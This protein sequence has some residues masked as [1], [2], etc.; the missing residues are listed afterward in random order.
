MSENYRNTYGADGSAVSGDVIMNGQT[1]LAQSSDSVFSGCNVRFESTVTIRGKRSAVRFENCIIYIDRDITGLEIRDN[2]EISFTGCTFIDSI[3]DPGSGYDDVTGGR[4]R[5]ALIDPDSDCTLQF[6]RCRFESCS[7]LVGND[8]YGFWHSVRCIFRDCLMHNCGSGFTDLSQFCGSLLVTGCLIKNDSTP[9]ESEEQDLSSILFRS[10]GGQGAIFRI[11]SNVNPESRKGEVIFNNDMF[12][13]TKNCIVV[14]SD[15]KV[16]VKSCTFTNSREC[17][18]GVSSVQNCLFTGCSDVMK[19]TVTVESCCFDGCSDVIKQLPRGGI[20]KDCQFLDCR[21]KLVSAEKGGS[22]VTDCEFYG[23]TE[24][25]FD[26]VLFFTN[27]EFD[28][29]PHMIKDCR[30]TRC[31][32]EKG[33]LIDARLNNNK[34]ESIIAN[35]RDCVFVNTSTKRTDK[36]VIHEKLYYDF[37]LWK[38]QEVRA[39]DF[40]AFMEGLRDV[41]KEPVPC[42]RPERISSDIMGDPI[43][44]TVSP[45]QA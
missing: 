6:T 20:V 15:G 9:E 21:K 32:L 7:K 8:G 36:E 45:E 39:I 10:L 3:T 18:K 29:K 19:E 13:N 27:D 5:K 33:Y 1:V 22:F 31:S 28:E 17:M 40:S 37:L 41:N 16:L 34:T 25:G 30:F 26:P 2:A 35:V 12:V 44:S 43:G 14:F 11:W 38:D 23:V 42:K 4:Y 24:E